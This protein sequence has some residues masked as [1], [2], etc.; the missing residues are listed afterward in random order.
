MIIAAG[1]YVIMAAVYHASTHGEPKIT[2]RAFRAIE[3]VAPDKWCYDYAVPRYRDDTNIFG[4]YTDIY[5]K[6]FFDAVRCYFG[7]ILPSRRR[8]TAAQSNLQMKS[9]VSSWQDDIKDYQ[10]R[11]EQEVGN[12]VKKMKGGN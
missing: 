4:R 7:Y 5:M 12:M 6:T 3:A 11:A 10:A 9:L 1:L 8:R 2:Y